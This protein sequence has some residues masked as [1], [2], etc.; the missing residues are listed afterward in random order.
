MLRNVIN[1]MANF[2]LAAALAAP[3]MALAAEAA[4]LHLQDRAF[5]TYGIE[6]DL[7]QVAFGEIAREK[8]MDPE[9]KR[10]AT[11]SVE[12]HRASVERLQAEAKRLEVKPPTALNPVAQR[13]EAM[14]KSLTGSAFDQAFLTSVVLASFN[15]M[16]S[17][18]R[19]MEHGF[20][21]GLR[22]EGARQSRELLA[23]RRAAERVGRRLKAPATADLTGEDRNFLLYAMHIDMAQR[24]FA[25]IAAERGTDPRV[26]AL[27]GDLVKYHTR[28]YDRLARVA[29]DRGV[30]P[31]REVSAITSG[32]TER[33]RGMQDGKQLDWTFLNA[34]A[35]T[36]YGAHYRYERE[37]IAGGDSQ[38]KAIARE[39]AR[40]A[41]RQH[42]RTLRIMNDGPVA[43]NALQAL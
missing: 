37:S 5:M 8:A 16:Y 38:V 19:Q 4:P 7:A 24:G 17:A 36:S 28:S 3:G 6:Q 9:V 21:P 43:A 22:A 13:T 10:L 14:L 15:G 35:F 42:W 39:E 27:A 34:H 23:N 26:R 2:V 41:R 25:E 32:T 31:L 29:T 40:E 20:E 30:E 18:R 33:L 11:S 12:Y 1:P